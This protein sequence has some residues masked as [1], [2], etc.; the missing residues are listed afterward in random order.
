MPPNREAPRRLFLTCLCFLGGVLFLCKKTFYIFLRPNQFLHLVPC[1][2]VVRVGCFLLGQQFCKLRIQLL[3][4]RQLLKPGFVKG[5]FRR[6]VQSN[7]LP[8]SFQKCFTVPGF[9]ISGVHLT[10]LGIVDDVGFQSTG[11]QKG[12]CTAG[13]QWSGSPSRFP[14]TGSSRWPCAGQGQDI[15]RFCLHS[16]PPFSDFRV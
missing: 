10:G 1:F 4:F 16:V 14:N 13:T 11:P 12:T 9:P 15:L 3:D 7:F 6:L 2:A 5:S 8:M